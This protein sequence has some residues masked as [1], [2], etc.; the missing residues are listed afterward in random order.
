MDL[1]NCKAY[2]IIRQELLPDIYSEGVQLRH[3]KSGARICLLS[4]EDENKVFYVGFRTPP[5]DSCGTAHIVEHTVLC[6]SRKFPLKDPF[7]ELVKGSLN[8]FLNAMTYPDKTVYPVAS[9]ND[10]DFQNL[11]DVYLDSVF[12]PNIY[13]NENIFRQEGWH[14]QLEK[15]SDP[16]TI[17]GVVYNEMRGAYSSADS[18]LEREILRTLYP[19][20]CYAYESGGD[21]KEIPGLTYETYLDFHRRYYHPSNSY[22][23]LYGNMDMEE[24]LNWLD[25]EYLSHFDY[26]EVDS[27]ITPQKPFS[28]TA[29]RI[30]EYPVATSESEEKNS[31]LSISWSVATT[32]DPKTTTAFEMLDYVLLNRQGSPIRQALIDAGIGDDI[33]GGYDSGVMQP[34]FSV[35]AKNTDP[36][37][38][39]EFV[40]IVEQTL[41]EQ[42][43]GGLS[44]RHL[45]A[46]INNADFKFREGDFGRFPKGL[47]AGLT[48]LDSWLYDDEH[49]FVHLNEL[50]VYEFLREQIDTGYFEDLIRTCLVENPH[51]CVVIAK[52]KR[53]LAAEWEKEDRQRLD[54]LQS[55]LSPEGIRELMQI[56]E[57]VHAFG[58]KESTAE[59]LATIPVLERADLKKETEP[60]KNEERCVNGV[61]VVYHE[62]ETNGIIYTDYL[63]SLSRI[64]EEEIPYLGILKT[65]T[66]KVNAG[67]YSY[68]DLNAEVT[69][70]T[71][72]IHEEIN[73]Y[74]KDGENQGY[75]P[76]LEVRLRAL[77]ANYAKAVSLTETMMLHSHF[78]DKK[79]VYAILAE[80]R[81]HMQTDISQSGHIYGI[82][83][84]A[85][86]GNLRSAFLER[87]GGITY[88]KLL[89]R[90]V[91]HFDEEW[92]KLQKQLDSLQK[93]IFCKDRLLISL[94]CDASDREFAEQTGALTADHLLPSEK[95]HD[96]S[97]ALLP[98]RSEGFSDASMVQYVSVFGR[99]DEQKYPYTGALRVLKTIL[100]YEYLWNKIRVEG[101]AYGASSI[102]GRYG[103]VAM[104]SYRD[105][106]LTESMQTYRGMPEFVTQ[107]DADERSMNKYVIGTFSEMDIPL[108]PCAKGRRSLSAYLC[109]LTQ[110]QL[111]QERDEILSAKASDIRALAERLQ[112]ALEQCNF[113]VIGNE[114]KIR[115]HEE[116]FAEVVPLVESG[117]GIQSA[118][119]TGK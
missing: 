45:L 101:G 35:I 44:K 83:R 113:C 89:S 84:A 25:Q 29:E 42:M 64:S 14:Y 56:T 55:S 40:K 103:D 39:A 106:N 59:E 105:P 32:P 61:P 54:A 10:Q 49:P 8:T 88:F 119:Q 86:S 93:K 47:M 91:D 111:Q 1:N 20:T 65:L 13:R 85:A 18:V 21:P 48:M 94:T 114:K 43:E 69:L 90:I 87:S 63:F 92:P 23:Y 9:C 110:D 12:Y 24:K 5:L 52:P 17:N 51:R 66:G 16:L 78:R 95:A 7:I 72:G 104:T 67:P 15:E 98:K 96:C 11:M 68:Q 112:E 60:L 22:I 118:G 116:L 108:F 6:G 58:N 30:R 97:I 36:E 74:V 4:N 81:S 100:N 99:Y 46:A 27:S 70:Y 75:D 53:G 73:V 37:R 31:Y 26:R 50:P 41:R 117:N 76:R 19:D 34:Y 62:Y 107:F 71:G 33:Y 109:G 82:G 57:D 28:E 2:E 80:A 115:E 102:L 38:R 79:R 3:K 77:T